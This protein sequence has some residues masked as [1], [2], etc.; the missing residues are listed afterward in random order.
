M[1]DGLL[2]EHVARLRRI[3][4]MADEDRL[5]DWFTDLTRYRHGYAADELRWRQRAGDKGADRIAASVAWRE[6][7]DR[8]RSSVD[9]VML[10][11]HEN[12]KARPV[13]R[14]KWKCCCPFHPDKE[15]SL[16][17]DTTKGVWICRGCNVG[18]DAFT[19]VE[20]RYGLDFKG[21]VAHLEQRL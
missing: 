21:A 9:L 17:I 8:V 18:G 19:Y 6:R 13:G 16:D 10:I 5:P 15:P 2:M 11:A 4:V 20:L 14:D 7:V 12:D 3:L 1:E